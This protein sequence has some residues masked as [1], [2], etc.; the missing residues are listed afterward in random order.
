MKLVN[1]GSPGAEQPG[2]LGDEGGILPLAGL[3]RS[4]GLP[5][6]EMNGVIGLLPYVR[7]RIEQ[8]LRDAVDL[9]DASSVR[10]GPPVPHPGR[11]IVC[12]VNYRSQ[13]DEQRERTGGRP[14]RRPPVVL[15]PGVSGPTDPVVAW[16]GITELE[17]EGE[18]VA[19]IGRRVRSI[20]VERALEAVAGYMCGQDMISRSMMREDADISALYLQPTRAKGVDTFCPTGPWLTTA[21]EVPDYRALAL[22]TWVDDELRQHALADEMIMGLPELIS[23]LSGTMTLFPGDLVFTGTPA[24]LGGSFDPPRELVPGQILRTAITGLGELVNPIVGEDTY[25][26]RE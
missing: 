12:G 21:D 9:I 20:A 8:E 26:A 4:L 3:W 25:R 7:S 18:L 11:I 22:S 24:G 2:V 19:V 10:L 13:V 5:S 16:D 6:V 17:Y 1:Y 14:P 23:W 15:R